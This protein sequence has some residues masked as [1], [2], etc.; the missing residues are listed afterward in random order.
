MLENINLKKKLS[1]EEYKQVAPGL[2]RRLF[3]LEESCWHQGVP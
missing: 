2:Q 1:R 3:K